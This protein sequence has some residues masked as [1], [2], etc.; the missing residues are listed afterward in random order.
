MPEA[1]AAK[2]E[3]DTIARSSERA[4]RPSALQLLALP[5]LLYFRRP[6]LRNPVESARSVARTGPRPREPAG[7][8]G[9]V[10]RGEICFFPWGLPPPSRARG[11]IGV[12]GSRG[13]WPRGVDRESSRAP[14]EKESIFSHGWHSSRFFFS[15]CSSLD[16]TAGASRFLRSRWLLADA[17]AV[18]TLVTL[19]DVQP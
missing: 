5:S 12:R 11:C 13:Q 7:T 19:S 3:G 15:P 14:G 17:T 10:A 6:S 16:A 1:N 2:G 8:N 18:A 9:G 4:A